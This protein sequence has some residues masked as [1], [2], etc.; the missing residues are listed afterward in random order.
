MNLPVSRI[1]PGYN[2]NN[3]ISLTYERDGFDIVMIGDSITNMGNWNK[4]LDNKRIA[5][6]G[7]SGDSTDGVLNRL[8]DIYCLNP[9]M[10]FIMIGINDFQGNRSVEDVMQNYRKI[11]QEIKQRNIRVIVQ[12]VLHLGHNYYIT[13]VLGKNKSDWEEINKKVEKLN[14]ELEK[15]AKEYGVE[16]ININTGLSVNNI[17]EE[18]YGDYSGLHL[19]QLGYEKW[20]EII[21]PITE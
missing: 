14:E 2:A 15:L 6:L 10:C 5:N 13:H 12:S 18:K 7:I 8:E 9:K 1:Y 19:S 21:K 3:I 16:F 17:L 11:I 4:I 20:A